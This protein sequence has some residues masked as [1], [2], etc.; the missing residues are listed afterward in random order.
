MKN[1]IRFLEEKS[2]R[3]LQFHWGKKTRKSSTIVDL[4]W[5]LVS[6]LEKKNWCRCLL[7]WSTKKTAVASS[8]LILNTR[9]KTYN[10]V[11]FF[12]Y[13]F[14]GGRQN[15]D[16][17]IL[18]VSHSGIR[19]VKRE[20]SQAESLHVLHSLRLVSSPCLRNAWFV[21]VTT[22]FLMLFRSLISFRDHWGETQR[23][24]GTHWPC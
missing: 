5:R 23:T 3:I 22:F 8:N 2:D 4:I 21:P 7:M 24:V 19:L 12:V 20:P 11:L 13:I 14:K 1:N 10:C 18:A 15:A 16:V 17:Q 9:K 6:N